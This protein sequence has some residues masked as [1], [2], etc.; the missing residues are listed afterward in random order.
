MTT[1]LA[2]SKLMRFLLD[3]KFIHDRFSIADE[4]CD[5]SLNKSQETKPEK[6]DHP[7][8]GPALTESNLHITIVKVFTVIA[9]YS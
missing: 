6:H 9:L 1:S 5:C 2:L 8:I 3:S 4:Q 7:T